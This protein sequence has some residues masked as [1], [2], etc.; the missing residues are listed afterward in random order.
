M[1]PLLQ[2]RIHAD[3]ARRAAGAAILSYAASASVWRIGAGYHTKEQIGVGAVVGTVAGVSWFAL[4]QRRLLDVA[5]K[6]LAPT[7]GKVP[8]PMVVGVMCLGA[9]AVGSVERKISAWW[10]ARK[11]RKAKGV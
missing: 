9:G 3:R 7:N 8:I 1:I 6:A 10:S 4:C 5:A 11:D 2:L